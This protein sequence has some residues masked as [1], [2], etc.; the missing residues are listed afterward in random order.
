MKIQIIE[1]CYD[2]QEKVTRLTG[3]EIELEY[4]R[5]QDFINANVAISLEKEEKEEPEDEKNKKAKKAETK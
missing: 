1:T 5:A 2:R 3:D 4:K